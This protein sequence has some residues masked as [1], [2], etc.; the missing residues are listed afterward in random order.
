M[1]GRPSGPPCMTPGDDDS[2]T[3]VARAA[4]PPVRGARLTEAAR[5]WASAV[6]RKEA[7]SM[8]PWTLGPPTGCEQQCMH[9]GVHAHSEL[10]P[11]A[12]TGA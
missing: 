11:V 10:L 12:P 7:R 2:P 6:D 4:E 1:G 9:T 3:V 8:L 5:G